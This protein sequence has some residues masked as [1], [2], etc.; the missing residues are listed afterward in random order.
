MNANRKVIGRTFSQSSS[1]SSFNEKPSEDGYSQRFTLASGKTAL[2]HLERIDAKNVADVTFVKPETNGR[3]QSALTNE[4]LADIIRTIKLQQFF[5]AIGRKV[6]GRIEILDGSRRRAS[7]IIANTGLLILV[8]VA[9]LS[10]EDARQLAADIQTAKEHN[11]RE[12]GLRL[13]MLRESGMNQ[14]DIAVSQKLSEAKVTRAIQAAL[15]P[16]DML[17]PFPVQSEL[18]YPDYKFLFN[19]NEQLVAKGV[20]IDE[21]I[22][23]VM[24]RK[25]TLANDY[26][27]EDLKTAIVNLFKDVSPFFLEQSKKNTFITQKLWSFS[28]KDKYARK[29]T[30][31]RVI[32]YEF[33]R[34]P[35]EL[36]DELDSVIMATIEKHF[37]N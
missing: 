29:K 35:K 22:D 23:Q 5:P 36:H 14:K 9:D 28:E 33:S 11:L 17:V 3:D 26:P 32:N 8:T 31:N 30:K 2:F 25:N 7:A 20:K 10:V 18:T 37:K 4:S 12:I 13:L 21:V 6:D 19:L 27:A 16:V 15:V 24:E 34:L 1:Q